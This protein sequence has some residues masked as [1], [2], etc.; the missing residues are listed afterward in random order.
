MHYTTDK[1]A[2]PGADLFDP[3]LYPRTY[4]VSTGNR[5]LYLLLGTVILAGG[6]AGAW[7]FGTGHEV[8][9]PQEG[10]VLTL[11]C[12]GFVALG[13]ALVLYVLT[14]KIV[15]YADAIELRDFTRVRRRRRDDI[16]GRRKIDAQYVSVIAL[17][18]K[19]PELKQLKITQVMQTDALLEAWLATLPDL[20]AE[21]LQKSAAEIAASR[22]LG[23][24]PDQ[25][26]E[27]L[28]AAR[29]LAKGLA[30][31]SVAVSIWAF[32]NPDPY[33]FAIAALAAMP[34]IAIML[35]VKSSR[36]YQLTGRRNDARADL[37]LVFILP[38]IL[39]GLRALLD[40]EILDWDVVWA[41]AGGI[42]AALTFVVLA[43]DREMRKS[44]WEPLAVLS[45]AG[46]FAYGGVIEA[47]TL[48]DR[49]EPQIF[50]TQVVGKH[51]SGGN[52]TTY[53]LRVAPW[54]PLQEENEVS[55]P[56]ALYDAKAPGQS[57]CII[58]GAGAL[59]IP[60][61]VVSDCLSE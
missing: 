35:V 10:T 23:R 13:G 5:I 43:A 14:S 8:E 20:D 34:L 30:V 4:R 55:V 45:I 53:Y 59:E 9:T 22:D 42:A 1:T 12:L 51:K 50:K 36:L 17:V 48:L 21:D 26:L 60:W 6:L 39:L 3:A 7:Y 40:I 11:I 47:N 25:R 61:F 33:E 58:F 49:S 57:V 38:G 46:F 2:E 16:A 18:P 41:W 27:R 15:L 31:V 29:R 37:A 44:R 24:T 19:R 32:V 52:S 28:V 56:R 54:G